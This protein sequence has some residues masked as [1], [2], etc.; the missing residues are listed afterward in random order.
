MLGVS[1]WIP[2]I[3]SLGVEYGLTTAFAIVSILPVIAFIV[4]LIWWIKLKVSGGYQIVTLKA[5]NAG[6]SA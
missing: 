6:D 3:G 5:S 4:Y 2:Q 1:V